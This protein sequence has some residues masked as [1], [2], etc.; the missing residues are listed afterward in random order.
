M[1]KQTIIGSVAAVAMVAA[2]MSTGVLVGVAYAADEIEVK[3]LSG[4]PDTV[5]G[6]DALLQIDVPA[7]VELSDVRVAVNGAD[8]TG[9]FRA[10]A[11]RHRLAGI[12]DGLS[13][14]A[15]EV[16]VSVAGDEAGAAL[17]L[18]NHPVE[19]PVFSGPHEQPFVCE[20]DAFELPSGETL[21]APLDAHCSVARRVDY[22]YR[23]ADGTLKPL[24][25]PDAVPGP[26]RRPRPR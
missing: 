8:A 22:A 2:G 19:G 3:V 20:T 23:A 25:D 24:A 26:T 9:A 11:D 1:R 5:S 14:G 13:Q 15:N 21:G 17:E 7:D 10:D 16:T 6:G 12:V 4:R 18:V